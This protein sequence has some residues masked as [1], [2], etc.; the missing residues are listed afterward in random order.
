MSGIRELLEELNY[1]LR[2]GTAV[3][4]FFASVVVTA[5]GVLLPVWAPGFLILLAASAIARRK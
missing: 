3:D 1:V 5:L 4:I 2:K